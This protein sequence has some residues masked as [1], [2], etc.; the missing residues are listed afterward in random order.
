MNGVL[1]SPRVAT[2]VG[3]LITLVVMGLVRTSQAH[4]TVQPRE[5]AAKSSPQLTIRVPNEKDVP[6]ESVRLEFPPELQVLRLKP[7]AGWTTE[8]ERDANGKISAITYKGSTIGREEYQEFSLIARMPEATGP[9]RIKA[10]QNYVGG[11]KVA[12]VNDAEP[13]PA[14]A[15][16]V[17]AAVAAA[18]PAADPFAAPAAPLAGAVPSP[19]PPAGGT[20]TG[21]WLGGASLLLSVVA[22]VAALRPGRKA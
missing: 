13:Q 7:Q 9:I 17:T 18:A 6:T 3:L 19:A 21:T 16:N 20:N 11:V 22:L 4:V 12:W 5:A 10:Y 1:P 2:R 8:V 14:P 15:L